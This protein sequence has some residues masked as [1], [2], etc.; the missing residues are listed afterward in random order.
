MDFGFANP[1]SKK[2]WTGVGRPKSKSKIQ[3]QRTLDP[4]PK[5]K[6]QN[7]SDNGR[8]T[9][10]QNPKSIVFWTGDGRP[11]SKIQ[12][13]KGFG[14]GTAGPNPKS[15]IQNVLD[16]GRP[17]QIQNPK[18]KSCLIR[19]WCLDGLELARSAARFW[20]A[21]SRYLTWLQADWAAWS[22]CQSDFS[23]SRIMRTSRL[24]GDTPW[25]VVLADMLQ[26]SFPVDAVT[27]F[28]G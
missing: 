28:P 16:W 23:Q 17:A 8:A 6:I 7:F 22:G 19:S 2:L 13:P 27:L 9:Q 10:I 3:A 24:R 12:N 11:R 26:L 25:L 18:S 20:L 21:W 15:Q 4:N 14:L 5:S 1:K